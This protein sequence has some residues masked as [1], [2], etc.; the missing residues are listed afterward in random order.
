MA[1]ITIKLPQ[2]LADSV[3]LHEAQLEANTL[4]EALELLKNNH[5]KIAIHVFD[6]TGKQRQHVILFLNQTDIRWL[7]DP[8]QVLKDG[9]E[10]S[11]VQ[12]ISG[13]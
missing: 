10:L 8:N 2:L 9:D 12:A 7:K 6:T 5:P 13:G 4:P 1:K 11:I 3:G